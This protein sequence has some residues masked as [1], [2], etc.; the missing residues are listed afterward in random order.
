MRDCGRRCVAP[1][2]G[3]VTT[4][5]IRALRER[6][7]SGR[8]AR[9]G[10]G[11]GRRQAHVPVAGD[12]AAGADAVGLRRGEPHHRRANDLGVEQEGRARLAGREETGVSVGPPGTRMFTVTPVPSRSLAKLTQLASSAA[13]DAP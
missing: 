7:P 13:L 11:L 2:A 12:E 6:G 8:R 1:Q 9:A 3:T 4:S 5:Y 10:R